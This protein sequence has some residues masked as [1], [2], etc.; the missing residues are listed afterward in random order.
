[1]KKKLLI[2]TFL[3]LINHP[4]YTGYSKL[5]N[6][7]PFIIEADFYKKPSIFHKTTAV[8]KKIAPYS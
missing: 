4:S 2:I 8:Y 5:R 1:M 7:T 3:S 6:N